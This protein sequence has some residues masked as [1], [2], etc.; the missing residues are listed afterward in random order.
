VTYREVLERL[1]ELPDIVLD[2]DVI[3]LSDDALKDGDVKDLFDVL[4]RMGNT[5]DVCGVLLPHKPRQEKS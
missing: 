5:H 3:N 4:N 2:S 1:K